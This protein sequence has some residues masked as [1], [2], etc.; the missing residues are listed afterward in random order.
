LTSQIH[1]KI[2]VILEPE[3]VNTK[4][5]LM[6]KR[7]LRLFYKDSECPKCRFFLYDSETGE[8]D[9]TSVMAVT[10]DHMVRD[11][12]EMVRLNTGKYRDLNPGEEE[13]WDKMPPEDAGV[14]PL[15][16]EDEAHEWEGELPEQIDWE[17][18]KPVRAWRCG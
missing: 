3:K 11:G 17:T 12:V 7:Q 16:I 4:E 13:L 10:G 14:E 1:A 18:E 6:S 9:L 8:W 2:W 5:S 15:V